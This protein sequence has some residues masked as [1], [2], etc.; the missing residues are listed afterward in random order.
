LTGSATRFELA[1]G[2]EVCP[3]RHAGVRGKPRGTKLSPSQGSRTSEGELQQRL[4]RNCRRHLSYAPQFLL[5]GPACDGV[6]RVESRLREWTALEVRAPHD[7]G[8]YPHATGPV[9][10]GGRAHR[11]TRCRFEETA[12]ADPRRRIGEMEGNA[13][14]AGATGRC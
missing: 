1:G 8:T 6:G 7:L 10:G 3:N 14:F 13:D 9:Y 4:H 2:C 12:T 5:F 11:S